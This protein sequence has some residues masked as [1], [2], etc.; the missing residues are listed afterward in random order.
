MATP[1]DPHLPSRVNAVLIANTY[2]EFTDSHSI[3]AHVHQALVPAAGWLSSIVHRS[4]R[5]SD[6]SETAEHEISAERVEN[7]LRQA[8]FEIVSSA[9]S[10]H[11]KRS[12]Y[13]RVGG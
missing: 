6:A 2:H 11:R 12:R 8:N 5:S 10:F 1:D 4:Q 7:E 3:L 13:V 9:R